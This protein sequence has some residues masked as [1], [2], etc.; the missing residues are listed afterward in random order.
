MFIV[1]GYSNDAVRTWELGLS[2]KNLNSGDVFLI[3]VPEQFS[4]ISLPG[5][6]AVFQWNGEGCTQD[7]S[8]WGS[9]VANMFAEPESYFVHAFNEGQEPD[10]FWECFPDGHQE[11]L[12]VFNS[13]AP[14]FKPRLF[15]VSNATGKMGVDEVMDFTQKDLDCSDVYILDTYTE[16]YVWQGHGSNDAERSSS[17]EFAESYSKRVGA[18]R[19]LGELPVSLIIDGSEPVIFTACFPEWHNA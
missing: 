11:Y 14:D 4:P 16:C 19:Q 5:A 15:H 13:I 7:E 1:R 2:S 6:G 8:E 12:T 10:W 9:E 18:E 3:V 17:L